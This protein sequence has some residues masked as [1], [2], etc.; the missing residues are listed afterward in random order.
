MLLLTEGSRHCAQAQELLDRLASE[1]PLVVATRDLTLSA[2]R[3]LARGAG[4]HEAPAVFVEGRPFSCG[5]LSESELRR[6]LDRR[7]GGA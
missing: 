3:D 1:Y 7:L 5:R 4:L 6:D 2:A